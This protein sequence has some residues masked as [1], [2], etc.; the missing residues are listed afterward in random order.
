MTP[1]KSNTDV[2]SSQYNEPARRLRLIGRST[3]F[4]VKRHAIR[5]AMF[6]LLAATTFASTRADLATFVAVEDGEV[7]VFGGDT[8][9]TTDVRLTTIQSG[10]LER[11]I[12]LEF[13]IGSIAPGS[14]IDSAS[15][16]I[17]KDGIFSNTGTDLPLHLLAYNGDGVIDISD[18]DAVATNV[19]DFTINNAPIPANGTEFVFDLSDVA[20]LQTALDT[21]A[22]LLTVRLETDSFATINFASLETA[23]GFAPP[24]LRVTFTAIPEPASLAILVGATLIFGVRRRRCPPV[25]R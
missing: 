6:L 14:T 22:G 16:A 21:A 13:D 19:G 25:S 17:V 10:G 1:L 2:H 8:V 12:I 11:N 24:E 15:L 9:D 5:T 20:P 23:T 7:Q 3:G 4:R 18:F